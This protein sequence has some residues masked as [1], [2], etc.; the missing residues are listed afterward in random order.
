MSPDN[1]ASATDITASAHISSTSLLGP[2]IKVWRLYLEDQG[3]SIH[4]VKAFISDLNLFAAYMPPDS[5]H[6]SDFYQRY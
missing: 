6:R 1:Q 3:V 5:R 4:T 2:T